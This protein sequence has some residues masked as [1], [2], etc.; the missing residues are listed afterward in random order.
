VQ[1]DAGDQPPGHQSGEGVPQL[2]DHGDELPEVPPRQTRDGER[3]RDNHDGDDDADWCNQRG[4][5]SEA[6][7]DLVPP[8]RKEGLHF[9]GSHRG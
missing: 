1:L 4:A 7:D 3:D 9:V 6:F 5:V 8:L 2:V